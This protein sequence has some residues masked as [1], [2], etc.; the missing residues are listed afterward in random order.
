MGKS[1]LV[2]KWLEGMEVDN[3]RGARWVYGWSFFS[4]GTNERVTSADEFIGDALQWF[5]DHEPNRGSP[6]NKGER[7]AALV[8]QQRTLLVLDGIEPL[9]SGEI[10]DRGHI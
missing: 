8:R 7:L 9:Q 2:N 10:V 4:Q 5:G 1:T 6:W 3:Y